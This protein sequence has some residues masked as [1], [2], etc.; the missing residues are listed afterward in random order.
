MNAKAVLCFMPMMLACLSISILIHLE[1]ILQSLVHCLFILG[2]LPCVC[3]SEQI[4]HGC[5]FY[6]H[7][8]LFFTATQMLP[9]RYVCRQSTLQNLILGRQNHHHYLHHTSTLSYLSYQIRFSCYF[10]FFLS[11]AL[12]L[13]SSLSKKKSIFK[14]YRSLFPAIMELQSI[15][16]RLTEFLGEV[17]CQCVLGPI[18]AFFRYRYIRNQ[19]PK[20]DLLYETQE[21]RLYGGTVVSTVASWHEGFWFEPAG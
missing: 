12:S 16:W 19:H 21:S 4:L 6:D 10:F 2:D 7:I 9:L 8:T 13:S 15:S 17:G 18:S 11:I 1:S 20:K 3:Q 14:G 5:L